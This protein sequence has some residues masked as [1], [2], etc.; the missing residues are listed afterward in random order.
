MA[1]N[2]VL[3]PGT[4]TKYGTPST[5]TLKLALVS[6]PE[7]GVMEMFRISPVSSAEVLAGK[8]LAYGILGFVVA[9]LTAGLAA[10]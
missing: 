8:V 3:A 6:P 2:S 9:G 4:R 7:S 5:S 10:H 1:R